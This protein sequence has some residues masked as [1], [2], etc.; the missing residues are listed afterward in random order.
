MVCSECK[1]KYYPECRYGEYTD[2]CDDCMNGADGSHKRL[3]KSC[4]LS[5]E[6][7]LPGAEWDDDKIAEVT[8]PEAWQYFCTKLMV[9]SISPEARSVLL[10]RFEGFHNDEIEPM[11]YELED[12]E[13][14]ADDDDDDDMPKLVSDIKDIFVKMRNVNNSSEE[15]SKLISCIQ[16]LYKTHIERKLCDD[17][18]I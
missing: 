7:E 5:D 10:R 9:P 11:L 2:P 4:R 8:L 12:N 1:C 15:T 16:D 17:Y 14:G 13:I 6:T 18:F 3:P